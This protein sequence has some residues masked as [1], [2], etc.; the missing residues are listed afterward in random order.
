MIDLSERMGKLLGRRILLRRNS[1]KTHTRMSPFNSPKEKGKKKRGN[2]PIRNVPRQ[3]DR[4]WLKG[5]PKIKHTFWTNN[6]VWAEPFI[7]PTVNENYSVWEASKCI[8]VVIKIMWP[9]TGCPWLDFLLLFI[10][11]MI[12]M[13]FMILLCSHHQLHLLARNVHPCRATIA[14]GRAGADVDPCPLPC[15]S[16][17]FLFCAVL[18][19]CP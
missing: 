5:I 13:I 4:C 10:I 17:F 1:R 14:N 8:V 7:L 3:G 18:L 15:F 12:F 6:K 9:E 2:L 19:I 16:S 11:L